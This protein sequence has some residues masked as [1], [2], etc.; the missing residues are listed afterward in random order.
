MG[1]KKIK[2]EKTKF[3]ID[4]YEM[5]YINLEFEDGSKKTIK[6]CTMKDTFIDFKPKEYLGLNEKYEN[7]VIY[8]FF[9][10]RVIDEKGISKEYNEKISRNKYLFLDDLEDEDMKIFE[11]ENQESE[12][13]TPE[14]QFIKDIFSI[15]LRMKAQENDV[16]NIKRE[17]G[18]NYAIADVHG[19]YGT[20][21]DAINRLRPADKL[22]IVGDVID[23]GG[24]GI[25]I[26]KDLIE[27]SKNVIDSSRFTFLLGNHE[28]Q[29]MEIVEVL[30]KHGIEKEK[31]LEIVERCDKLSLENKEEYEKVEKEFDL[32]ETEAKAINIWANYN[33]GKKTMLDFYDESEESQREIKEFLENSFIILPQEINGKDYLFVHSMPPVEKDR[34]AYI[35][36]ENKGV[37]YKSSNPFEINHVL[38]SRKDSTYKSAKDVGF[39]TICGHVSTPGEIVTNNE[40]GFIRIDAGC[41]N[42][43][44]NARLA[45]YCI[46]DGTVQYLE[47]RENI[48]NNEKE[49]K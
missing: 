15:E 33:G 35:K 5:Y 28:K 21:L 30:K 4:P 31:F 34:N 40:E 26:L 6:T 1:I 11:G 48:K 18:H 29:F 38:E 3:L 27:K 39:I 12:H 24:E 41:G 47:E 46:D 42:K 13:K 9:V 8:N 10:K 37:K 25:R 16:Q 22:Y 2:I 20:Y 14:S 44:P 23:R 19:M 43:E 45:L 17:K 36:R 32:D 49:E 7:D